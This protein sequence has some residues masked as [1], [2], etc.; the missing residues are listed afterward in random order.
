MS[1]YIADAPGAM[2]SGVR[3]GWCIAG[4]VELT[5][6]EL[7]NGREVG[8]CTHHALPTTH[9]PP[10]TTHYAPRTTHYTLRTTH[11]SLTHYALLTT[12]SSPRR[13]RLQVE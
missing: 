3:I 12:Y 4:G 11:H 10:R 2:D 8:Y 9:H 7:A 1:W 5:R 13:V 6:T